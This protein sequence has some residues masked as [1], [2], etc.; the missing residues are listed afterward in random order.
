MVGE[1]C[2][3]SSAAMEAVKP[4]AYLPLGDMAAPIWKVSSLRKRANS[5]SLASWFTR[6]SCEAWSA[7]MAM[8]VLRS[9]PVS[10][11]STVTVSV[12]SSVRSTFTHVAPGVASH[13]AGEAFT[14][15]TSG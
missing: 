3:E 6:I 11:S 15:M 14:S 1:Y 8:V 2:Q 13:V 4:P 7:T 10:L 12:R 9:A 5:L